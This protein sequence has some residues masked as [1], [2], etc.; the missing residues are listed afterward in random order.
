MEERHEIWVI[1]LKMEVNLATENDHSES[2]DI[3]VKMDDNS[4]P[5]V[6]FQLVFCP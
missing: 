3:L 2:V 4:V 5:E 1:K 6:S